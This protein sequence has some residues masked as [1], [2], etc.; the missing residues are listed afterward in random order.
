MKVLNLEGL[1]YFWNKVNNK[2]LPLSGGTMTGTIIT[3][4]SDSKGVEPSTANTGQLGSSSKHFYRA[5]INN[6]YS[7][8]IR[9]S[10]NIYVNEKNINTL[11]ASYEEGTFSPYLTN[12]SIT[13]S[14]T[15]AEYRKVGSIVF[16]EIKMVFSTA[17]DTSQLGAILGLPFQ[18]STGN[19]T[20]GF[21]PLSGYTPNGDYSGLVSFDN[22]MEEVPSISITNLF[23]QQSAKH[24]R[25]CGYYA[26]A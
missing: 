20:G 16:I 26:T 11:Y 15:Q 5:Y 1:K 14:S 9:A 18:V 21:Y 7:S 25:V 3:P 23:G 19:A 10:S 2:F 24:I 6:V 8:N 22:Y 13:V 4:A 17:V 12:G